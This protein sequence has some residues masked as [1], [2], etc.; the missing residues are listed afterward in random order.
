MI[1]PHLILYPVAALAGLTFFILMLVP[2]FRFR[3]R[4]AGIVKPSDFA[5]GESQDVPERT[6]LMNRNYMNLLELPVLFYVI[7][8]IV[9]ATGVLDG[10]M[11]KLSWAYVGL[12][13]LHSLVHITLNRVVLRMALFGASSFVLMAMWAYYLWPI[14]V[15]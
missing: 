15:R 13:A 6:R 9:Y 5:L 4:F 14:L 12:R 7:C 11:L 1:N 10:L 3:D 8:L 2:I